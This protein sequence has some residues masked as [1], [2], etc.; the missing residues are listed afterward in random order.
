MEWNHYTG[1]QNLKKILLDRSLMSEYQKIREEIKDKNQLAEIEKNL[2]KGEGFPGNYLGN[3]ES[4]SR[5]TRN[6]NV[7][8]TPEKT[9]TGSFTEILF[10]FNLN[11]KPNYG[12]FFITPKVSLDDLISIQV[13][14]SCKSEAIK[15]LKNTSDGKYMK[16]F[17]K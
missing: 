13:E 4:A 17:K 14:S 1:L 11:E 6:N 5:Y 10:K 3:I 8:L 7:F 12:K 15:I 9:K 2:L 16:Y